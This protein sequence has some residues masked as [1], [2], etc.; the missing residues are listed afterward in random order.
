MSRLAKGLIKWFISCTSIVAFYC[1]MGN[2]G[3]LFAVGLSIVLIT[4][5]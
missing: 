2:I 5:W 1:L 3:I 4:E